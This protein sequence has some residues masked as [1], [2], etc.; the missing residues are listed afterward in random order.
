MR[1][2]VDL[3]KLIQLGLTLFDAD[4]VPI[5]PNALDAF[6]RKDIPPNINFCPCTW[7]FNFKFD[8]EAEMY[9]E[10]SIDLLKRAG[11]DFEKHAAQGIDIEQFSSLLISSGM[12]F[13]PNVYWISFHGGYDFGYLFKAMWN[14]GLP[15]DEETYRRLVRKFFPNIY[16]VK[17]II[18]HARRLK[19]RGTVN[20]AMAKALEGFRIRPGLQD[21]CDEL[22]PTRIGTSH[23]AGSDAWLTGDLFFE[24][25]KRLFDDRIPDEFNNQIWGITGIGPPASTQQQAAALHHQTQAAAAANG[26]MAANAAYHA[27]TANLHRDGGPS[28]PTTNPAGLASTPNQG[29]SGGM[30]PGAGGVFGNF[31]YGK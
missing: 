29:F 22:G 5:P 15:N 18:N 3:L 9:N 28:T 6:P 17:F 21:I 25:R 19:E 26:L 2:N 11:A 14:R 1:A 12:T 16:D 8:L 24:V 30:T 10:P 27:S 4:G 23:T 31:Q 13:A 20:S 7:T